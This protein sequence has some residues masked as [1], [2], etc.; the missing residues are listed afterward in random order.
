MPTYTVVVYSENPQIREQV[1]LAV[2]RRPADDVEIAWVETASGA[3]AIKAVEDHYVDLAVFDGEAQ[4]TG[5]MGLARQLKYEVPDCPPIVVLLRRKDDGWLARWSLAEAHLSLPLDPLET[6]TTVVDLL[7][8][9]A[10][11]QPG[12]P[13]PR[14]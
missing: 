8:A 9:G 14:R 1:L 11:L 5:G 13:A 6:S 4:P 7:R 3:E 2:G 10:G 12:E